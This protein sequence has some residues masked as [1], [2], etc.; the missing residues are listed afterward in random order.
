M[1]G[2]LRMWVLLP[3][4]PEPRGALVTTRSYNFLGASAQRDGC[5]PQCL[6]LPPTKDQASCVSVLPS[7]RRLLAPLSTPSSGFSPCVALPTYSPGVA[8]LYVPSSVVLF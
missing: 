1:N 2:L 4:C 6:R 8:R 3:L 5:Q 7:D